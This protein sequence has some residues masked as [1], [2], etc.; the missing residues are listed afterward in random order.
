MSW[1]FT[2]LNPA[3]IEQANSWGNVGKVFTRLGEDA[4]A[5]ADGIR[6]REYRQ[7]RDEKEDRQWLDEFIRKVEADRADIAYKHRSLNLKELGVMAD[8]AYKD[9]SISETERHNHA[10]E[11]LKKLGLTQDA[12][13]FNKN[14]EFKKDEANRQADLTLAG[15]QH[16]MA[17]EKRQWEEAKRQREQRNTLDR[18]NSRAKVEDIY[19]T[20]NL[21]SKALDSILEDFIK[22]GELATFAENT[23]PS[24]SWFGKG[25]AKYKSIPQKHIDEWKKAYDDSYE[26][27]LKE[28]NDEKRAEELA[29]MDA[30]NYMKGRY[31]Y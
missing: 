10:L 5:Q 6:E 26:K 9:K 23:R 16:K 22:T 18:I 28:L 21:P 19:K 1:K 31:D 20:Q 11:A 7:R 12:E 3:L 17:Q 29:E 14:L 15:L 2:S 13:H 27:R 4:L 30:Y 8:A 24:Y 25:E